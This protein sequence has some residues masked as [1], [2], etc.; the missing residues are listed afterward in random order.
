MPTYDGVGGAWRNPGAGDIKNLLRQSKT[1]AVVGLSANPDRA[2][3]RVAAYLQSQGYTIIPVNP[4]ADEILGMRTYPDLT[5]IAERVDIVDVFRKSGAALEITEKAINSRARA[6]WLQ[7]S[8]V[9]YEAFKR[10]ESAGLMMVMDR[11]I[12]REHRRLLS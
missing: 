2:S 5:A 6:V 12:L 11:C 9:S 1:I 8:V 10:G 3:Y 7:E 4:N